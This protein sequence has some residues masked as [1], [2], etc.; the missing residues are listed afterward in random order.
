MKD[1]SVLSNEVARLQTC[2]S[3]DTNN[4]HL[5]LVEEFQVHEEVAGASCKLQLEMS[6]DKVRGRYITAREAIQ[7]GEV[8]FQEAPFSCVLL[9]P[10][11][12]ATA[13]TAS[14]RC[15]PPCPVWCAL[16]LDIAGNLH[17]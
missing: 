3:E 12:P 1:V 6:N 2:H 5:K 11:T 15:W 9:P 14:P 13:T 10:S 16:S 8:V 4:N 7:E 17:L